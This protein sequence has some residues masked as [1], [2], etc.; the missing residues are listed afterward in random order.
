MDAFLP[1]WCLSPGAAVI[2]RIHLSGN[3]EALFTCFATSID[4]CWALSWS[5][6]WKQLV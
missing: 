6:C 2:W 3:L 5:C 1:I 4:I